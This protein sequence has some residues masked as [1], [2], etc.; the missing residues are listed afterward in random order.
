[1]LHRMW[2][3]PTN[4]EKWDGRFQIWRI[5]IN[6]ITSGEQMLTIPSNKV[7]L[8][9]ALHYRLKLFQNYLIYHHFSPKNQ[10]SSISP[11]C[12]RMEGEVIGPM[13]VNSTPTCY[14]STLLPSAFPNLTELNVLHKEVDVNIVTEI[15]KCLSISFANVIVKAS[16]WNQ[17]LKDP[18]WRNILNT[19]KSSF[20]GFSCL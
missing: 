9:T 5:K 6:K 14:N 20:A 2:G 3:P 8:Y 12:C 15:K 18:K 19:R 13:L 1:M 16:V 4:V 17:I 10:T 7:R 11:T